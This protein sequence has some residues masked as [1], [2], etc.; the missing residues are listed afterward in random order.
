GKE[1]NELNFRKGD[2][3]E[4]IEKGDGPNSWWKGKINGIVGDFPVIWV[5]VGC[6]LFATGLLIGFL[7][8]S[9]RR[10]R[11]SAIELI[12]TVSEAKKTIQQELNYLRSNFS[13]KELQINIIYLTIYSGTSWITTFTVNANDRETPLN[14]LDSDDKYSAPIDKN[15]IFSIWP[16]REIMNTALTDMCAVKN[17]WVIIGIVVGKD[18]HTPPS[19]TLQQNSIVPTN[20]IYASVLYDFEGDLIEVIEKGDGPNSW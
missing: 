14:N 11:H 13:S 15:I 7:Y 19:P 8:C 5:V 2:L 9:R 10:K 16:W 4:V 3:I 1:E 20:V 18:K 12:L 17:G 6:T